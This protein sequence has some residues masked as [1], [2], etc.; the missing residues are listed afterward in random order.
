MLLALLLVVNLLVLGAGLAY[1][2]RRIG[3]LSSR[4][5]AAVSDVQRDTT[6]ALQETRAALTRLSAL[7]DSLNDLIASEVAPTM[8]VTRSALGHVDATLKGVADATTTVRRIAAGAEA[9]TA[10]SAMSDAM[11]R[12]TQSTAG[13]MALLAAGAVALVQGILSVR[14]AGHSTA[15]K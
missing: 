7:T 6:A 14:R 3:A 1:A 11:G 13:R 2:L 10:P 12:V 15:E 8:S 4:I 5:D 9:L